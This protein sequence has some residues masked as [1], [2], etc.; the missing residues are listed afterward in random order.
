M[1]KQT[2]KNLFEKI[3][4]NRINNTLEYLMMQI[5]KWLMVGRTG[6][7]LRNIL[8]GWS[9]PIIMFKYQGLKFINNAFDNGNPELGIQNQTFFVIWWLGIKVWKHNCNIFFSSNIYYSLNNKKNIV[10]IFFIWIDVKSLCI[11]YF[12]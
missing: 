12:W 4:E 5:F 2:L 6:F 9:D 1:Y 11:L 3:A 8:L 10:D 7:W